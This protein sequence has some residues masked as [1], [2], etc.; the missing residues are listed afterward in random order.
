MLQLA[1]YKDTGGSVT[2]GGTPTQYIVSVTHVRTGDERITLVD[3]V[4]IA[5]LRT[6]VMYILYICK[7]VH[8]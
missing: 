6:N 2:F 8:I 1:V 4:M 5:I 7:F 3:V